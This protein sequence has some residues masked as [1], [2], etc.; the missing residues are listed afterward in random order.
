MVKLKKDVYL[1]GEI[2]YNFLHDDKASKNDKLEESNIGIGYFTKTSDMSLYTTEKATLGNFALFTTISPSLAFGALCVS[3]LHQ[4]SS[5]FS[6]GNQLYKH[7]NI[8]IGCKYLVDDFT[9][10]AVK[11]DT[12]AMLGISFLQ[13]LNKVAKLNIAT[14]IDCKDLASDSHKFGLGITLGF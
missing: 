5:S 7:N 10:L 6:N 13:R 14:E 8:T 1:G 12:K 2:R 3:H 4:N 11:I 9:Q